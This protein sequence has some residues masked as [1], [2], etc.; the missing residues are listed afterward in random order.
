MN[1]LH[2]SLEIFISHGLGGVCNI[3]LNCK[4]AAE[5]KWEVSNM[6][7]F[8]AMSQFR[9][10]IFQLLTAEVRI[11]SHSSK[12]RIYTG[13][14][15]TVKSSFFCQLSLHQCSIVIIRVAGTTSPKQQDQGSQSHTASTTC[16]FLLFAWQFIMLL[17]CA[18]S[19]PCSKSLYSYKPDTLLGST[20][21]YRL[22][23]IIKI[24]SCKLWHKCLTQDFGLIY[25]WQLRPRLQNRECGAP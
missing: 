4:T 19:V 25:E 18:G 7:V 13:Q 24:C 6:T 5:G 15:G 23:S 20:G 1:N 2:P 12:C 9:K 21:F 8:K 22:R 17:T 3:Y 16:A 10:L 11:Q 14:N